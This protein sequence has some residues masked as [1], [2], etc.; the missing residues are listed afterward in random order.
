MN[1]VFFA[2]VTVFFLKFLFGRISILDFVF[3]AVL[4]LGVFIET[5]LACMKHQRLQ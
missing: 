5:I 4:L 2:V 1:A 3:F